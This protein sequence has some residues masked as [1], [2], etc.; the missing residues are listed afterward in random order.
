[1]GGETVRHMGPIIPASHWA[2]VHHRALG[3]APA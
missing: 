1:M 2:D 3:L